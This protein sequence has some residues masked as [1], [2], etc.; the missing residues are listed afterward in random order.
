M[1]IR[2]LGLK[3]VNVKMTDQKNILSIHAKATSIGSIA[4]D[5]DNIYISEYKSD[6]L[7][8]MYSK[9]IKQKNYF[10]NR[11]TIFDREI[12]RAFRESRISS[13]R[14]LQYDIFPESRDFFSALYYIRFYWQDNE[15][16]YLDADGT[17]WLAECKF[18]GDEIIKTRWGKIKT[19]RLEVEFSKIN[20]DR[21]QRS[22]MLTNNLVNE[23]NLLVLWISRDKNRL[24][25]K[26]K[27]SMKPISVYWILEDYDEN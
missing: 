17:S 12:M 10:E 24:P 27:Y 5:M 6:Y 23:D 3:V 1:T 15:L 7:P 22:D 20:S 26:A 13:D 4:S 8:D 14:N 19:A 2:F 9:S 18:T 25:L 16:L 11:K 21:A